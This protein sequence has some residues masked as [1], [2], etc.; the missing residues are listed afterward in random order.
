MLSLTN[1]PTE[2]VAAFSFVSL[3]LGVTEEDIA[4]FVC[5]FLFLS[6]IFFLFREKNETHVSLIYQI[7]GIKDTV[8]LL[9]LVEVTKNNK[10]EK[11]LPCDCSIKHSS[12]KKQRVALMTM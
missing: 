1:S 7:L 12:E 10:N 5:L 4:L 8:Y 11:A 9:W 2:D 3:S 6:I